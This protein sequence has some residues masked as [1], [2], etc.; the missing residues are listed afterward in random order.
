MFGLVQVCVVILKS[1][2]RADALALSKKG[3]ALVGQNF[4]GAEPAVQVQQ[5]AAAGAPPAIAELQQD[6]LPP[7]EAFLGIPA[8]AALPTSAVPLSGEASAGTSTSGQY[9]PP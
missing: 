8:G 6:A 4:S 7:G 3:P 9:A 5:S 2:M 1:C